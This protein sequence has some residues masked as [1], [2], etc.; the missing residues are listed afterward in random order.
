M[1][2]DLL[3]KVLVYAPLDRIKP[4]QALGHPYF[5]EIRNQTLKANIEYLPDLFNFTKGNM[6]FILFNI[7]F[8]LSNKYIKFNN[9]NCKFVL[10]NIEFF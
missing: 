8:I 3:S 6:I 10:K 1:V 5:N 9:K 2:I 4:I 7:I